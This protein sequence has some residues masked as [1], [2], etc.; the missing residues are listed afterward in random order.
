MESRRVDY[1]VRPCS[2]CGEEFKPKTFKSV[3]CSHR[4]RQRRDKGHIPLAE[5]HAKVRAEAIGRKE[6][7]CKQCGKVFT[8]KAG[9]HALKKIEQGDDNWGMFC[10]RQCRYDYKRIYPD[11]RVFDFTPIRFTQCKICGEWF[12]NKTCSQ[13]CSD[14]CKRRWYVLDQDKDRVSDR[15]INCVTCG[16][17]FTR[18]YKN[19]GTTCSDEC[20]KEKIRADRH[21]RKYSRNRPGSE[22]F[23]ARDIFIRDG[24]KCRACG[25]KT[26]QDKRGTMH[27]TAPELDHIIP[28]SKGGCHSRDNTQLLC[29]SCNGKKSDKLQWEPK[30]ANIKRL[31]NTGV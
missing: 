25:I 15:T 3:I 21:I 14:V 11:K 17:L 4:C 28:V 7:T 30:Q 16:V 1:P 31:T 12:I 22:R 6:S 9:G 2:V 24:W 26:P 23:Y 13:L 29:K 5:H 10:S 27:P 20:L 19:S 18:L 8:A